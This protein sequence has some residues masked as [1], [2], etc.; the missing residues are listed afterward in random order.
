[1]STLL[2]LPA[3]TVWSEAGAL[4]DGSARAVHR[5]FRLSER[6]L[7]ARRAVRMIPSGSR[8]ARPDIRYAFLVQA[9]AL[10]FRAANDDDPRR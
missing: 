9:T 8:A 6:L 7:A 3:G 4:H 10:G 1:M 5:L 2:T